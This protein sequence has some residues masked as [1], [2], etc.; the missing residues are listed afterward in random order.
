VALFHSTSP[1]RSDTALSRYIDHFEEY[2]TNHYRLVNAT[3]EQW[4]AGVAPAESVYAAQQ[5]VTATSFAAD[6]R[7]VFATEGTYSGLGPL[8]IEKGDEICIFL[9]FSTPSI[10]RPRQAG[11][12]VLVGECY[13]YGLMD[14]EALCHGREEE[15]EE[16]EED[17]TLFAEPVDTKGI[18]Y[19]SLFFTTRSPVYRPLS[20]PTEP[21]SRPLA[22]PIPSISL[23]VF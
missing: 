2:T 14:G 23:I 12:Y 18:N 8:G 6:A 19:T 17:V 13:I 1:Q 9:G 15:E 4:D 7:R 16:E 21:L 20:I 11:G 10:I 5:F 22:Q 3:T